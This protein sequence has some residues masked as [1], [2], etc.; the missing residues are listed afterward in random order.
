MGS[1][2]WGVLIQSASNNRIG[3]LP[4]AERNLIA[5]NAGGIAVSNSFGTNAI[6]NLL[7]GNIIYSN[8]PRLNID[9]GANGVTANDALDADEGPNRLQNRP[10]LTNGLTTGTGLV[11]A[12]GVLTSAPLQTY[13]VDIYRA[14][15][16]NASSRFFIG[17]TMVNT[18]AGG[19]G[20]FTAG[21]MIN[22]S[23]GTYLAATATDAD[24][25][26]SELAA[27]PFG[28]ASQSVTDSD[29]DGIPDYWELL[30]GLNPAVSNSPTDDL[31]QDGH[32]D[33]DEY[34]ADTGANDEN[35]FPWI[36]DIAGLGSRDVTF[37]SSSLRV[38]RLEANDNLLDHG[39]WAQI[40]G[41][42]TGLYGMTTLTDT[43]PA[44]LRHYR[45]TAQLP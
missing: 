45:I 30:Y 40:G 6:N 23:P 13:A 25:N 14:D 27:S 42:V 1:S 9:L 4:P 21:F 2:G 18:D 19:V 11:Y 12:Q 8:S 44:T 29:G 39:A 17:R 38:Y 34:R 20:L 43:N 37:P 32:F 28:L 33:V 35:D 26:T 15:G 22:L 7:A 16:T 41:S 31:D 5:Y 3:G 24:N 10:T 36:A